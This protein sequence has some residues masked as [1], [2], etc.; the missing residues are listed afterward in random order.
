MLE[1]AHELGIPLI[2]GSC[3]GAGGLAH[4]AGY[5]TIIREIAKRRGIRFTA[6]IVN[7]SQS[8]D[9]IRAAVDDGRVR[10]LGPRP[11]LDKAAIEAS[12]EI[13]AMMG[14]GPVQQALAQGADVVLAGRCADAAIFAGPALHRGATP[15]PTWHA[16]K[17][18]DKG[19]LATA[20]PA[21]GSPVLAT[22]KHDHFIIEPTKPGVRCTTESVAKQTLYENPNPFR[23]SL[24]EG[25]ICLDKAEYEQLDERRVRV[26][27]SRFEVAAAP[28]VKLEGARQLG[29]RAVLVAGLRDPRILEEL[30][31]FVEEFRANLQR[32]AASLGIE[33]NAWSVRFRCY[34][35]DAV[36]GDLE[37]HRSRI[38]HEVG[39]VVDVIAQTQDIATALATRA[40]P[41]GSKA[42]FNDRLG[43]GGNFAYPFSPNVLVGGAV[44]EWS[45]WHLLEVEDPAS[46][47]S[48]ELFEV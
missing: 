5:Q 15:S 2:L 25:D 43:G 16:A 37:P 18:I 13:V 48:I 23:I 47:F 31:A 42:T 24:P 35:R 8:P 12:T 44:Y 36:L 22:I 46:P 39:L 26:T 38:P 7:A 40:G 17:A 6:A 28:T 34:G 21:Q 19:Y 9:S 30:D 29:F 20:D 11:P 45:L 41:A 14:A 10:P 27:G 4:V 33:P 3:G 32:S 1:G